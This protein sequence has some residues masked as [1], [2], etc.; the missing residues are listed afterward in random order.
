[1]W[2]FQH[3]ASQAGIKGEPTYDNLTPHKK[4]VLTTKFGG[5]SSHA[6]TV[7]RER[8]VLYA[9]FSHSEHQLDRVET[10]DIVS[11]YFLGRQAKVFL[12]KSPLRSI[13]DTNPQV[14]FDIRPSEQGYVSVKTSTFLVGTKPYTND[15]LLYLNAATEQEWRFEPFDGIMGGAFVNSDSRNILMYMS[16]MRG[17]YHQWSFSP[18]EQCRVRGYKSLTKKQLMPLIEGYVKHLKV[19]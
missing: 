17:Q 8:G 7:A 16:Q 11:V 6:M 15:F 12:E 10:G 9:D 4:A 2:S 18:L 13:H 5:I 14:S 19:K 3:Y 1:M